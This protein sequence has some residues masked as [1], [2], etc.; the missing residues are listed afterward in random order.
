MAERTILIVDDDP[1]TRE[2][3]RSILEKE[4]YPV[5]V[6]DDGSA[7]LS[8]LNGHPSPSLILLDMMMPTVDGWQF[9]ATLQQ[10]PTWTEI[11]VIISTA[12]GVAS[13]E[14]AESLGA[15]GLLKKPFDATELLEPVRQ[16]C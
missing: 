10:N 15:V 4:G 6:A 12:M 1:I 5:A 8:Y 9:L 2:G 16:F 14:W 13:S 7:A 3:L 11:P